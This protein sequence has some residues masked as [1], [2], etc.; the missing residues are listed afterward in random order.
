MEHEYGFYKAQKNGKGTALQFKYNDDK[1]MVFWE[2][3]NQSG[4]LNENGHAT[5]NWENKIILK[6]DIPDLGRLK[7]VFEGR[8]DG[9]DF[10]HKTP[11]HNTSIK[12]EPSKGK[13]G[14]A[15]F[16]SRQMSEDKSLKKV[17]MIFT[18]EE[19]SIMTAMLN[20]VI[21]QIAFTTPGK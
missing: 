11:K 6:L 1:Q 19:G 16:V 8:L 9:I 3:A 7:S 21:P 20:Y 5:F 18:P 12:L 4:E 2:L 10:F 15:F 14:W 13:D 17:G